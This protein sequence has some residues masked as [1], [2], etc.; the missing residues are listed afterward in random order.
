MNYY[1]GQGYW[2]VMSCSR[3]GQTC[4]I[5]QLHVWNSAHCLYGPYKCEDWPEPV[6]YQPRH[7]GSESR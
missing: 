3:P 7:A 4:R 6:E 1:R 5:G 2:S